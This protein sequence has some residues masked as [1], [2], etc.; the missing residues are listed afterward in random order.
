MSITQLTTSLSKLTTKLF[1]AKSLTKKA[2]LNSLASALDYVARLLVGFIITPVVVAGLGDYFFGMWQVLNRLVGYASPTSISPTHALK[3]SLANMQASTDY[4]QKRQYVGSAVGMWLILLPVLLIFGGIITWFAPIWLKSA[5]A[6]YAAVRWVSVLLV[7]NLAFMNLGAIPQSVLQGEN[8]TY[9]RIGLSAIIVLGSGFL[10]YL[11]IKIG[12]GIVGVAAAALT[13]VMITGLF[14]LVITQQN[15]NWFGIARPAKQH[16]RKFFTLTGWFMVWKL[17]TNLMEASDVVLFGLLSSVEAVTSY[18]LTK[19]AAEIMVSVVGIM[20]Q[21]IVPGLGGIIGRG[22]FKKAAELRS[23]IMTLTWLI[24]TF[25]GATMLV[26]NQAFIKIWVQG[27]QYAGT[28]PNLLI[29][30]LVGQYVLI[31]N[32]SAIIDLTLDLKMKVIIGAVSVVLSIGFAAIFLYTLDMGVAGLCLGFLLGRLVL[33]LLYPLIVMEYLRVPITNQI[34]GL[35][36]PALVTAALY[37][38]AT[39]LESFATSQ[40]SPGIMGWITFFFLAGVTAL[41]AMAITFFL[42]LDQRR[43]KRIIDRVRILVSRSNQ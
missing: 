15:V 37:F 11:A 20:L 3:N 25:M 16:I 2:Y 27:D 9:K 6:D 22:D 12:T 19:Y 26:W 24:I 21:G 28:L 4:H 1:S 17:V 41:A 35:I 42:G 13:S 14:Y 38:G 30:L 43:Q 8:Q 23:E 40:I 31:H 18:T 34:K 29:V 10:T 33:T 39:R 36:R 7:F 5:P 32:D